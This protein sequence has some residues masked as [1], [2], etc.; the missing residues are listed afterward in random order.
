MNSKEYIE[1]HDFGYGKEPEQRI[2]NKLELRN[3][4]DAKEYIA[5]VLENAFECEIDNLTI[6]F[7]NENAVTKIEINEII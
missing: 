1:S 4:E 5:G 2:L 7:K 6:K 3:E